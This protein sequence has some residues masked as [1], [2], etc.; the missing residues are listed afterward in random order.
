MLLPAL[1]EYL[2]LLCGKCMNAT[3]SGSKI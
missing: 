1:V 2:T 3:F